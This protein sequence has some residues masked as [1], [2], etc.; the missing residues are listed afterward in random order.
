MKYLL[1]THAWVELLEGSHRGEKVRKI[2]KNPKNTIIISDATF[3][4]IYTWATRKGKN[5]GPAIAMIRNNSNSFNIYTNIWVEA[6]HEKELMRRTK[7]D[8]GQIDAL[9]LAI[10]R[11]TGSK[12]VTGDPHFEGVKDA[13]II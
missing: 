5:P 10:Q 13:I 6:A 9:L 2:I 4:E 11:V 12:I 1:D 8:F 7:K 3:A